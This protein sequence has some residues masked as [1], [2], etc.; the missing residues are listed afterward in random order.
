MVNLNY[1][2]EFTEELKE[3]IKDRDGNKCMNNK[4]TGKS[5]LLEVHH[6]DYDK[7]NCGYDN[8]IT[9]CNVCN[10]LANKRKDYWKAHYRKIMGDV[11]GYSYHVLKKRK[12]LG[13]PEKKMQT[14]RLLAEPDNKLVGKDSLGKPDGSLE[15]GMP[16]HR[17]IKQG[18]LQAFRTSRG[19]GIIKCFLDYR[20][21]SMWR[22]YYESVGIISVSADG[23]F[24]VHDSVRF[25]E[26]LTRLDKNFKWVFEQLVKVMPKD[27]GMTG[28]SMRDEQTLTGIVRK[29]TK[30]AKTI[31]T[32]ELIEGRREKEILEFKQTETEEVTEYETSGINGE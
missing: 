30:Q 20:L 7:Q 29:V 26:I 6:I 9:I 32:K 10:L 31:K 25:L 23:A 17:E 13:K 27:M 19:M 21:P 11:H 18:L 1:S 22:A 24:T 4:C 5:R 2:F 12:R 28:G 8:L 14:V 15:I 16:D 3:L